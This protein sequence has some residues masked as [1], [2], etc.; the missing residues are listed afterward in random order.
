MGGLHEGRRFCAGLLS[1]LAGLSTKTVS[2]VTVE[3]LYH[4]I[5]LAMCMNGM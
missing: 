4:S 1:T 3:F 5:S 2:K